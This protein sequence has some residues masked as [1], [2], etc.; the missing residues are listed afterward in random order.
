MEN[1][2]IKY[3]KY[4]LKPSTETLKQLCQPKKFKLQPQQQFLS[5][6]LYD[7]KKKINGLLIYHGIGS[8]KTCT[9]INIAEKFK[10]EYNIMV[11]L[12][13]AL[14]GNFKDELLSN[15]PGENIYIKD[16]ERELYYN[17]DYNTIK[18]IE[19]RINEVYK[20]YSYNKFINLVQKNKI[21]LK[22]TILI[23]DEIQNMI[24]LTG[25]FYRTLKLIIDKTDDSLKV[26]L[27]S[28]TP[29]INHPSEISLILNL[30]KPKI[31]LPIGNNFNN[32]YLLPIKVGLN[33][34]YKPINL[35]KFRKLTKN[36]V[37][38]YRGAP[39]QSFP[40]LDFNIVKCNMSDFQ[41][42]SY[43]T[44]LSKFDDNIKDSFTFKNVD[45]LKLP[46]DFFLG[47]RIISNIAFPNKSID[48]VGFS[49]FKDN[50]LQLQNIKNYSIKFYK[51]F[52]KI[53]KSEGPIFVY[54]NFKDYGGLK[55]FITFIE[56]H[57]YKN[58]KI[59][60]EGNKR[61]AIWSGDEPHKLKE[62]IKFI[63]NNKNNYNGSKIKLILGSPSIKEGVSL[64]RVEQIH[65]LEP[66]WNLARILQI[67]G[68]GI[69]FCSHKDVPKSKQ[70]VNVYLYLASH[71][72]DETIDRYIWSLAKTKYKIINEFEH[73]LKENA[74]DCK[75]F[76][77]R[78]NF[79]SDE[80][81]IKCN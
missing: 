17:Q 28:A 11:V 39:E 3:K 2:T 58:Y 33:T 40:K 76:L 64:L 21:K 27:L 14:I 55:S 23:I 35:E 79:K 73:I 9:A 80:K 22:N 5:E 77:A 37:S 46:V 8:G 52:K 4:K 38:Y 74:I 75:L 61:Y 24:S 10:K 67:I 54:S 68:R 53:K 70:I 59:F 18:I 25:T 15:C 13:A 36:L 65:I 44:S 78:N 57:G 26:F 34:E 19:K 62:E 29:I 30:L 69:R 20:I 48:N 81:K 31:P 7:N 60:G 56:Y 16:N 41:Y 43:L 51:I 6:F 45:I 42:K 1:L 12:P 49:S 50:K 47:P 72:K 66:Y 32:E 71:L 63:F